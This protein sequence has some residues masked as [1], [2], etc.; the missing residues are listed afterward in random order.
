MHFTLVE[1]PQAA[2]YS[3]ISQNENRWENQFKSGDTILVCDVG[4]GTTDFSLIEIRQQEDKLAFQRMAVGDHLLLGGDNIDATLAHH[5][6]QKLQQMGHPPLE[7]N[8][9]LQL[10]AEARTAK[11]TLLQ[12]DVAPDESFSVVLQGT[13]S[14]VVKGSVSV[15]IN[16]IE[17]EHLLLNG[18]FGLYP[19]Q[20]ALQLRRSRGF[21]T[22][23]LPYEDEPSITKHLAHF[24]QQSFD[25]EKGKGI[26]YILF[27]GGTLKPENLSKS[28]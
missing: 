1:E 4:G 7:S 20:E 5:L 16:R 15:S 13:G 11:E 3:W 10:Q 8:Q 12:P 26:D 24:L 17:I 22:M 21:R 9:W 18:F 2:F 6:E 27:N 23:G 28:H 25:L 14:A 19:L